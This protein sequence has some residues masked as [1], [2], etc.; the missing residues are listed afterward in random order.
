MP[1]NI[2]NSGLS[3]S[4]QGRNHRIVVEPVRPLGIFLIGLSAVAAGFLWKVGL[5]FPKGLEPSSLFPLVLFLPV[6]GCFYFGLVVL[7]NRRV[8]EIGP[9]EVKVRLTPLPWPGSVKLYRQAIA[10]FALEKKVR[11]GDNGHIVSHTL[12]AQLREGGTHPLLT[13]LPKKTA[14]RALELVREFDDKVASSV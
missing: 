10:G 2:D 3:W 12:V 5:V 13:S 11:R 7:I 8:L 6:L 14:K 4:S 1:Q 9:K